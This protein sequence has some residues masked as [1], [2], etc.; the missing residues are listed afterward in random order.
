MSV[1]DLTVCDLTD[2]VTLT[3]N[4]CDLTF[5]SDLFKSEN[6]EKIRV[7]LHLCLNLS[8]GIFMPYSSNSIAASRWAFVHLENIL[9]VAS[10]KNLS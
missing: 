10:R 9:R 5:V 2:Y 1:C 6:V 8:L 4:V 3:I 7:D